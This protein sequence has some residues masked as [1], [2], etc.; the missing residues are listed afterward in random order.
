MSDPSATQNTYPYQN[1]PSWSRSEKAIARK[2][3]DAALK[4]ELQDIMQK[5][6]QMANQIKEPANVWELERYLTQR[7]KDIDRKYDFRTSRLTRVFGRL[8]CE[9]RISEK[10]LRG[11]R[12]D[13]MIAIHSSAKVLSE[14]AA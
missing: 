14:D 4:R 12:E 5:A 13:K 9:R 3:F 10:E 2:V 7:R 11:L 8:L 6:K 1:E